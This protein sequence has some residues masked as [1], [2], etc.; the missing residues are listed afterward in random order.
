[1]LGNSTGDCFEPEPPT[2][3]TKPTPGKNIQLPYTHIW[4]ELLKLGVTW[5]EALRMPWSVCRMLFESRAEAYEAASNN[6]GGG[7]SD[8]YATEADYKNW[9]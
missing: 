5:D 6:R 7:N 2:P 9:I 4:T 3:T 8:R 1:M